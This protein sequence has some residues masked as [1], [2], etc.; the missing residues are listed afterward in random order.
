[1]IAL[2]LHDQLLVVGCCMN[3]I[4]EQSPKSVPCQIRAISNWIHKDPLLAKIEPVSDAGYSS[5]RTHVT[6]EKSSVQ[7]EVLL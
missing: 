6:K 1:M 4:C 2:E 3:G 5:V 7:D